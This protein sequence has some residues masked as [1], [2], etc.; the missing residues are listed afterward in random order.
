[1]LGRTPK[2]LRLLRGLARESR[3]ERI[4]AGRLDHFDGQAHD[5]TVATFVQRDDV[6]PPIESRPYFSWMRRNSDAA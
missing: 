6:M 3:D 4:E 1:M 5:R 2:N